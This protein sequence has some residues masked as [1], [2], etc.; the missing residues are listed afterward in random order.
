MSSFDF[1]GKRIQLVEEMKLNGSIRGKAVEKAFLAVPREKFFPNEILGEA[2]IDHAFP[3]GKGQT[4]S[5]P[6]TIAVMLEMLQV[7]DGNKVLEVGAGSGYVAALLSELAGK[8]G[9]VFGLELL[10]ELHMQAA[11]TL[12]M[13]GYENIFLKC[14]DGTLGWRQ[15]APFDRILV[16]AASSS[17]AKPLASQL[18][19]SG[20]AVAPIGNNFSQEMVLFGKRGR[21]I[22]EKARSGLFA[23]VPL[24]GK[25]GQ[26]K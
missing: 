13:L 10:H 8:T 15:Q 2:Y 25:H 26:E 20:C 16:S 14:G 6:S 22:F 1:E 19:S 11:K 7:E 9:A 23:F 5:Q 21:K 18:S 4:I 12:A 17:F 24:K 3:I